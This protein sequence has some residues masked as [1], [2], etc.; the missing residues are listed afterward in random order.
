NDRNGGPHR[1]PVLLR[2]PGDPAMDRAL[3][4]IRRRTSGAGR[5][6]RPD[7]S[8]HAAALR[9]ALRRAGLR[10]GARPPGWP[11]AAVVRHVGA[12]WLGARAGAGTRR[13][14]PRRDRAAFLFLRRLAS[15]G[16]LGRGGGAAPDRARSWR[17]VPG[18][19][20]ARRGLTRR[21]IN[22]RI[23][24]RSSTVVPAFQYAAASSVR[25]SSADTLRGTV[26]DIA[27]T[28]CATKSVLAR[29]N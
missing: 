7:Q 28:S 18:R 13:Q 9:Q 5:P 10:P 2:R 27:A 23:H 3:A 20:A 19:A 1:D 6:C 8:R 15:P 25:T 22:I 29:S 17:G 11:V 16:P 26:I 4:R 24:K 12:R 21:R 14:A